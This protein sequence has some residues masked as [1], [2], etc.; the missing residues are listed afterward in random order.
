[1]GYGYAC[2]NREFRAFELC[3]SRK[4]NDET[5]AFVIKASLL[6]GSIPDK[7]RNQGSLA[8]LDGS[9]SHSDNLLYK[10]VDTVTQ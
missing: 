4:K 10:R 6:I 8:G 2:G 9:Q 1:M 3:F 7:R 5:D